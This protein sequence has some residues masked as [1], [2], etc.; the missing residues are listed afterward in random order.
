[1][2]ERLALTEVFRIGEEAE[3]DTIL[4]GDILDMAVNSDGQLFLVDWDAESVYVFSATGD[5]EDRIGSR[6]KGPGEFEQAYGVAIGPGESIVVFDG[7]GDRLSLFEPKSHRFVYSTR[8]NGDDF[9]S[10]SKLIGAIDDGF[11][12]KFVPPYWAPG[13][14]TGLALDTERFAVV[15]RVNRRGEVIGEPILS[16][17]KREAIVWTSGGLLKVMRMPFGRENHFRLSASGLL[18]SG[19]NESIDLTISTTD[20]DVVNTVQHQ[21][22][23]VPVK[24][25]DIDAYVATRSESNRKIILDS[26]LH[27]TMPA[28]ETFAVDDQDRIWVKIIKDLDNSSAMWH[29]LNAEGAVVAEAVLPKSVDLVVIRDGRAYGSGESGSGEPY[30]VAYSIGQ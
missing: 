27:E 28:Y 29:I 2:P 12:V 22:E 20:G 18:Y 1:M 19:W 26:D 6:G 9:S 11:L 30:V 7:Q 23:S 25:K 8:V 13:S 10:P 4:F 3:Q 21:H 15:N 16:L 24:N 5:L 14:G 17:P